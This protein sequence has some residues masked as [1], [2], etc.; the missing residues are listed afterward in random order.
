MKESIHATN[1]IPATG[2]RTI[3]LISG[4][5]TSTSIDAVYPKI[6]TLRSHARSIAITRV[7]AALVSIGAVTHDTI[8]IARL[9]FFIAIFYPL[10]IR[11]DRGIIEIAS[12]RS[13]GQRRER[14]PRH[15][16]P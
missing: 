6:W 12:R 15:Q 8:R 14:R 1:L 9:R 5:D 16:Q 3:N 13:Y 2:C 11:T 7:V 10:R 4:P